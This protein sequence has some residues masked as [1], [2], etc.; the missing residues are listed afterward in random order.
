MMPAT[1]E[2]TSFCV[3]SVSRR[4]SGWPTA[5][6]SP[7]ATSHSTI[8]PSPM[9]MPSLGTFSRDA[10]SRLS[11]SDPDSGPG[12]PLVEQ[13]VEVPDLGFLVPGERQHR[14]A[15]GLHPLLHLRQIGRASCRER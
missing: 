7:S 13:L 3:L 5:T 10:I 14:L 2:G 4:Y 12:H 11:P 8:E 15:R 6:W 9:D 1:G